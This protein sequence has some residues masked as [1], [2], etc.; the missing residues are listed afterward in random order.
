MCYECK[1]SYRCVYNEQSYK[2]NCISKY[3]TIYR[4]ETIDPRGYVKKFY[5]SCENDTEYENALII[6][7]KYKTYYSSCTT[8]LCNSHDGTD[9]TKSSDNKD[10]LSNGDV[11]TDVKGIGVNNSSQLILNNCLKIVLILYL[12]KII[13]M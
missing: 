4:Q 6:T 5:R 3:C 10:N 8:D 12:S 9:V 11:I 13:I 2:S 7:A 1:S